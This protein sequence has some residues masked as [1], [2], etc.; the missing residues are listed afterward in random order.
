MYK[1][2]FVRMIGCSANDPRLQCETGSSLL[3]RIDVG[4]GAN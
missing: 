1:L 4:I 2:G 3:D